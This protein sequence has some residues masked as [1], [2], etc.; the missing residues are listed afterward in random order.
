MCIRCENPLTSVIKESIR[1]FFQT[2]EKPTEQTHN[3]K[4]NPE[5][6][7]LYKMVDKTEKCPAISFSARKFPDCSVC[8]C[9]SLV[10][11]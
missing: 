5:R 8:V 10:D 7:I 1:A 11:I 6:I 9:A 4:K 3:E 2:N